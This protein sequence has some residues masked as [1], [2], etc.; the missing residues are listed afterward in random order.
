[1]IKQQEY[2]DCCGE[3]INPT[4]R[5]AMN[6]TPFDIPQA[7]QG[8]SAV[9]CVKCCYNMFENAVEILEKLRYENADLR[10][11]LKTQMKVQEP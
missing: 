3:V 11:K 2:C 10:E 5:F 9:V 8:E 6:Q 1:M 7:Y 4:H